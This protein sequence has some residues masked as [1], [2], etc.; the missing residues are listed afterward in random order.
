[1]TLLER[2]DGG[3][4]RA[5]T[6]IDL[7]A[8]GIST[9]VSGLEQ[10]VGT[11]D[12]S[13]PSLSDSAV[14]AAQSHGASEWCGARAGQ[15]APEG[16]PVAAGSLARAGSVV[17]ILDDRFTHLDDVVTE[18]ARLMEAV[19]GTIPGMRRVLR[20]SSN[21]VSFDLADHTLTTPDT[22]DE[23]EAP[24]SAPDQNA[25]LDV[26]KATSVPIHDIGTAIYLSPDVMA[27]GGGVGMVQP[28]CLLLRRPW[29]HAR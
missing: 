3:V 18:M 8:L 4:N 28:V 17:G 15:R 29:R 25:A 21:T 23:K 1:M 20:V 7:A 12:A 27:L 9:A 14:R 16:D 22:A 11:L 19:V 5:G 6:G 13:L 10:A 2:I 26:V 24:M